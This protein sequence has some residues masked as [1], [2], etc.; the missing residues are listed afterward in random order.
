MQSL[1]SR[2]AVA[3]ALYD[4]A[5]S[6]FA[7]TVM[8]GFFPTFFRQFW[9]AGADSALTTSRLGF[10]NAAAGL[11][12]GLAAPALGVIADRSG[13]RKRFLWMWSVLGI[14]CTFGLYGVAQGQWLFAASLF[15]LATLGF[16]AATVFYDAL[17]MDVA[18][19]ESLDQVSA[20]GYAFGYLGGGLLFAFN[21]LTVLK[22]QWFGLADAAAAVRFSFLTV[23]LWWL[24]F[25]LPLLWVVREPPVIVSEVRQTTRL[26]PAL[27]ATFSRLRQDKALGLFL[28]AYWLYIDGVYT[29]IKM[30]VDF[31]LSLGL[32]S[33]HLLG[34]LLIT[35][36]VAFPAALAFGAL[37]KRIG[38]KRGLLIGI[39]VYALVTLWAFRLQTSAEFYAMAVVVGLVQ[40]GVQSLSRSLFGR[41]VPVGHSAEYFGL[42]NLVGKFG[43]LLGPL[44]MAVTALIWPSPRAPILSLLLLFVAGAVLLW[45]VPSAVAPTP[46]SRA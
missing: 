44:L 30:A 10:A 33:Q 11:L 13:R 45:R 28:L 1:R 15:V 16:S 27:R 17:L 3:W 8:A 23:G 7:C 20:M 46:G 34:A 14:A 21:V 35:Q 9:S 37:G 40:G 29:I 36:F 6:A 32:A 5:N 26:W 41:M 31:G 22:P 24:L 12:I 19:K 42:F 43:T 2:P 4:W 38:P 18:P 25:M 39:M